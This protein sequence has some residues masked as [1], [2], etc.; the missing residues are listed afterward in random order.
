M[1]TLYTKHLKLKRYLKKSL[2]YILSLVLQNQM[3]VY[4]CCYG[5]VTLFFHMRMTEEINMDLIDIIHNWRIEYNV[6][7]QIKEKNK[8]SIIF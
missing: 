2:P 7:I 8:D 6:K 4:P 1:S 3:L 5:N